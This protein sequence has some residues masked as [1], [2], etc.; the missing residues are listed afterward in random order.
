L[1]VR[2]TSPVSTLTTRVSMRIS[3]LDAVNCPVSRYS[4]PSSL[5]VFTAVAG[6]EEA[7]LLQLLL[8]EDVLQAA[9]AR[10]A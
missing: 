10:R 8:G 4:A 1:A 3:G 6:V 5:P 7:R 9:R 2:T